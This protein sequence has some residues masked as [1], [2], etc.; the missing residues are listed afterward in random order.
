[1][2]RITRRL[3]RS[4]AGTATEVVVAVAFATA[5]VA[6]RDTTAAVGYGLASET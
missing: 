3:A 1:M 2:S 4:G 6:A 5:A